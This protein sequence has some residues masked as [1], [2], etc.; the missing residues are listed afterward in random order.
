MI[1]THNDQLKKQ[2]DLR[3]STF[4]KSVHWVTDQNLIQAHVEMAGAN[5]GRALELCC[6]TGAVAR[7][8][9]EAGWDVTGVD[10]SRSMIEE[11]RK[12]ISAEVADAAKLPFASES[13]DL[14]VMR[15]AYFLL[16]DGPAVLKEVKRLLKP[17]G[18][19]LLSH[20]VPFSEIDQ[21]HLRVVHTKKQAQMRKFHTV[22]SLVEELSL[23]GFRTLRKEFVVVRESVSLWMQ[24]APELS[25]E[26]RQA[27]CDLVVHAP[28]DYRRLRNVE[29]KDGEILEDWNFVLIEASL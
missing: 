25:Q 17:N 23:Q 12:Y 27:V 4:E 26:T 28:E 20:L 16:N 7:G 11:A 18:R 9:L 13:F 19:F 8:L 15:Q 14:I 21:D 5:P 10:I 22:R 1:T 3:A 6:G 2:F 29:V 24:E